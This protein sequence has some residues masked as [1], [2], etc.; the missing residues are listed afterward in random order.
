MTAQTRTSVCPRSLLLA[1]EWKTE[2][3]M[4]NQLNRKV[5]QY[6]DSNRTPMS[7]D[8]WNNEWVQ[9]YIQDRQQTVPPPWPGVRTYASISCALVYVTAGGIGLPLNS[10]CFTSMSDEVLPRLFGSASWSSAGC[11]LLISCFT[12]DQFTE[13][14]LYIVRGCPSSSY[15]TLKH[16]GSSM[17]DTDGFVPKALMDVVEQY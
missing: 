13:S 14:C 1:H 9:G 11:Y 4:H 12:E 8:C 2:L 5:N 6:C 10:W 16:S 7:T 15:R 17:Q 3:E